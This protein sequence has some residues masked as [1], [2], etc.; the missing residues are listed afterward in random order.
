MLVLAL[1]LVLVLVLFLVL[2]SSVVG[3]PSPPRSVCRQR[4]RTRAAPRPRGRKALVAA[5]AALL[6]QC[7]CAM[8]LA[9]RPF[10]L[11]LGG[12]RVALHTR[13]S[14][15]QNAGTNLCNDS[16]RAEAGATANKSSGEIPYYSRPKCRNEF[17][18]VWHWFVGWRSLENT[19]LVVAPSR[20]SAARRRLLWITR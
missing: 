12:V 5:A 8:S 10:S 17:V 7:S 6:C 2:T 20:S 3:R 1:V 15:R 13:Y 18:V 16:S 4:A 9:F 11:C 19:G 14:Y